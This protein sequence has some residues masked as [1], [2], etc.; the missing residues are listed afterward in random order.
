MDLGDMLTVIIPRLQVA[1]FL[2]LQALNDLFMA[3]WCARNLTAANITQSRASMTPK[4]VGLE[5]VKVSPEGVQDC[6]TRLATVF[7][8]DLLSAFPYPSK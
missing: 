3:G 6:M 2:A 8:G 4:L 1:M 5:L 7:H